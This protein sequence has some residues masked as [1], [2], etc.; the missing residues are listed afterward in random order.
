MSDSQLQHTGP[1]DPPA[2]EPLRYRIHLT[3][4]RVMD[5]QDAVGQI[6]QSGIRTLIT[7]CESGQH[8]RYNVRKDGRVVRRALIEWIELPEDAGMRPIVWP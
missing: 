2:P 6:E 5:W 7:M 8:P 4:G 1:V 3:D